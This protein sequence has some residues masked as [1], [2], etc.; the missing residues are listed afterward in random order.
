LLRDAIVDQIGRDRIR[1]T[2]HVSPAQGRL[3]ARLYEAGVVG[4]ESGAEDGGWELALDAPRERLHYLFGLSD[5]DGS[6][7]RKA[8]GALLAPA[9]SAE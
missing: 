8:L 5:G 7:L 4:D 6:Y 3:R 9:G 1:I 2:L